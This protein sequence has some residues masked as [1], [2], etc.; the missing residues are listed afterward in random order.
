MTNGLN[1]AQKAD[2]N[3]GPSTR[4]AQSVEVAVFLIVLMP[5]LVLGVF[6]RR[7]AESG[8]VVSAFSTIAFE[9]GLVSLVLYF[10]WR[11]G[12]SRDRIGWTV[13]RLWRDLAL[14]IGLYIPFHIASAGVSA[15]VWIVGLSGP[16]IQP[17]VY[18][19]T[20]G[21]AQ[22]T[23]AFVLAAVVASAEETVF[24]GYL[25]LRFA[26]LTGSLP[27]AVL[28]ST[29]LFGIEHAYQGLSSM[30]VVGIMG[31]VFAL[32]YVWRRSLVA[33]V[34][35]HLLTIVLRIAATGGL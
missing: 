14:G 34:V 3:G 27:V 16:L 19:L 2:S 7:P 10:L 5:R 35:L 15:F 11:N 33:P 22:L 21:L 26:S 13:K 18:G 1:N 24:R 30:I 28:L 8:F 12:E 29:L 31:L 32:I 6:S 20:H 23:L 17:P 25:I 4:L 9:V